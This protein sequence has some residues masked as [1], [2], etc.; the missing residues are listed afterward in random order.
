[1][2]ATKVTKVCPVCGRCFTRYATQPS[3]NCSV[4]CYRIRTSS[5]RFW[6]KVDRR[7]DDDC[8]LWTANVRNSGYGR[9]TVDGKGVSAHRYSWTL[10]NGPIPDGRAVCHS[11]DV[12]YPKGDI[13]NRRCVNPRHLWLGS[14]EE[15]NA[16]RAEKDRNRDQR[17]EKNSVAKLTDAQV[18]SIREGVET[19]NEAAKRHHVSK[20]LVSQIRKRRVWAHV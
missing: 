10:A 3:V 17:G 12:R 8:W 20:S 11:C 16:D 18:I 1:M 4:R 2:A 6:E 19:G 15:N 5:Q 13:T 7:G 9:F 14:K